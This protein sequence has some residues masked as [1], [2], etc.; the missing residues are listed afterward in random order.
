ML[1]Y[2]RKRPIRKMKKSI[3]PTRMSQSIRKLVRYIDHLNLTACNQDVF[4]S[5]A[6]R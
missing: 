4:L 5:P 2:M 1:R 3:S 6:N